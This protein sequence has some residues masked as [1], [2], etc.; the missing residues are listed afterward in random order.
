MA[1]SNTQPDVACRSEVRPAGTIRISDLQH[2]SPQLQTDEPTEDMPAL[3]SGDDMPPGIPVSLKLRQIE[4]LAKVDATNSD[5]SSSWPT[6]TLEAAAPAAEGEAPRT[7]LG[8]GV[9]AHAAA[10]APAS[11]SSATSGGDGLATRAVL[12]D[13]PVLHGQSVP[14]PQASASGRSLPSP[15]A[16]RLAEEDYRNFFQQF[17]ALSPPSLDASAPTQTTLRHSQGVAPDSGELDRL[18]AAAHHST[19]LR[20]AASAPRTPERARRGENGK[21]GNH[22][23]ISTMPL[24][25]SPDTPRLRPR[26]HQAPI[27]CELFTEASGQGSMPES[28]VGEGFIEEKAVA[29]G[30]MYTGE[31]QNGRPHG[32]GTT[33]Y[34]NGSMYSGDY[35]AG[36][37]HGNGEESLP[38]GDRYVGRFDGGL[39]HGQGTYNWSDGRAYVGMW[40]VGCMDGKGVYKWPDGQ[41][42]EGTFKKDAP[43]KGYLTTP[44]GNKKKVYFAE[45]CRTIWFGQL[46]EPVGKSKASVRNVASWFTAAL[47]SWSR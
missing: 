34:P 6:W 38:S 21:A 8:A 30:G 3:A 46:A 32:K 33:R 20:E 2:V 7:G 15:E 4:K 24:Q 5:R 10:E 25:S 28:Y 27:T 41:K 13:S 31:F 18:P 44:A 26:L 40:N 9:A 17:A 19:E 43:V 47:G 35:V 29:N 42:L 45:G 22:D 36:V 37:K 39:L 23:F 12:L 14:S 16:K 1:A 11:R